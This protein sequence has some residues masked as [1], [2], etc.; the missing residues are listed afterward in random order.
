M[1]PHRNHVE[2]RSSR[3]PARQYVSETHDHKPDAPSAVH[4][5]T[6]QQ[7]VARIKRGSKYFDQTPPGIWF[8]VRVVED[9]YFQLRGNSNN[10]R[11]SDVVMGVRL[12]NGTVLDFSSGRTVTVAA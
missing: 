3:V 11:I 4:T 2:A 7:L 1:A 9:N 12:S 5:S 6:A 10:Y 8:D